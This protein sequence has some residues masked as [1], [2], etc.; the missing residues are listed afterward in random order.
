MTQKTDRQYDP[1]SRG[2]TR[3]V[4]DQARLPGDAASL[5]RWRTAPPGYAGDPGG[6]HP[7]VAAHARRAVSRRN[8][9]SIFA[10]VAFSDGKS[11]STFPKNALAWISAKFD[12]WSS[13][14]G[15]AENRRALAAPSGSFIEINGQRWE[16]VPSP[17]P[18]QK[19]PDDPCGTGREAGDGWACKHPEHLARKPKWMKRSGYRK[20]RKSTWRNSPLPQMIAALVTGVGFRPKA[21]PPVRHSGSL[22]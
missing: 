18:R 8:R 6:W 20:P 2:V 16:L 10:F 5:P 12:G 21:I 7:P 14:S 17:R 22:N 1:P 11:D 9:S 3:A 19:A 4:L 15:T 13:G